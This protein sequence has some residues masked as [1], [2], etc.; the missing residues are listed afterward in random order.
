MANGLGLARVGN[1]LP[2]PAITFTPTPKAE[3][4]CKLIAGFRPSTIYVEFF[5]EPLRRCRFVKSGDIFPIDDQYLP[6]KAT[7]K[8]YQLA[9]SNAQA[10]AEQIA[11]IVD[12]LMKSIRSVASKRLSGK[13]WVGAKVRAATHRIYNK[14]ELQCLYGEPRTAYC[15]GKVLHFFPL[16]NK[17]F[18]AFGENLQ[19]Q[20]LNCSEG[21][22]ELVLEQ[23]EDSVPEGSLGETSP[24]SSKRSQRYSLR[25]DSTGQ[26]KTNVIE[27][28]ALVENSVKLSECACSLCGLNCNKEQDT[29]KCSVCAESFHEYCLPDNKLKWR[30]LNPLYA[31]LKLLNSSWKCFHCLGKSRLRLYT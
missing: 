21:E 18:V 10:E 31:P 26:S 15:I 30:P 6:K 23:S 28:Q 20:W 25:D 12:I 4:T 9:L 16:L 14:S 24:S 5:E 22:T 1:G 17:H 7:T 11:S 2:W 3:E 13:D 27:D 29:I 8:S 19:P